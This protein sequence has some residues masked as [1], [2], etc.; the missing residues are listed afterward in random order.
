MSVWATVSLC[1]QDTYGCS[2]AE[3]D[4]LDGVENFKD[5]RVN[6]NEHYHFE[7][8][9]NGKVGMGTYVGSILDS[10]FWILDSGFWIPD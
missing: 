7:Q 8:Y 4:L 6:G 2:N 3:L 5:M 10:G 9:R 1:S